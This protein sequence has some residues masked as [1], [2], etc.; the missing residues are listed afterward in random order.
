MVGSAPT[1]RPKRSS[2]KSP[3]TQASIYGHV[4]RPVTLSNDAFVA[5]RR[6]KRA[7]ESDSTVIL[8]LLRESQQATHRTVAWSKLEPAFDD[9]SHVELIRQSDEADR[10]RDPWGA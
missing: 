4:T 9:A 5:L 10:E 6:Q 1:N 7:H 8:R 2:T 3:Y